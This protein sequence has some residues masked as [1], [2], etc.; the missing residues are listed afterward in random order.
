[1]KRKPYNVIGLVFNL[2]ALVYAALFFAT[3]FVHPYEWA[4]V[5][6]MSIATIFYVLYAFQVLRK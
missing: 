6:L 5:I 4:F 1:M 2:L 3:H